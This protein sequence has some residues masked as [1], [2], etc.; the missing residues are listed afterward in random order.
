MNVA[1]IWPVDYSKFPFD[2][3]EIKFR[4]S[5]FT[6]ADK[7]D[8]LFLTTSPPSPDRELD[9]AKIPS[10]DITVTYLTGADTLRPYSDSGSG[11]EFVDSIAGLNIT[12]KTRSVNYIWVYFLPTSLFT[13]TSWF[14]FLL[15]PTSYP[16]RTGSRSRSRSRSR[17]STP[18]PPSDHAPMSSR[19]VQWS[20]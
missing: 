16:A 7:E 19:N 4:L 17:N 1:T 3:Q 5:S 2:T 18:S 13:V 15:P 12:L 20:H 14:S 10:Y 6:Y 9:V 11:S 8:L